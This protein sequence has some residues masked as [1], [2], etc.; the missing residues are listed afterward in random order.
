M[1]DLPFGVDYDLGFAGVALRLARARRAC[2]RLRGVFLVW[3]C[4]YAP[5]VPWLRA[6]CAVGLLVKSLEGSESTRGVFQGTWKPIL[7]LR[8]DSGDEGAAMR[9]DVQA[10]ERAN[11]VLCERSFGMANNVVTGLSDDR[12]T[13]YHA[14]RQHSFMVALYFVHPLSGYGVAMQRKQVVALPQNFVLAGTETLLAATM[15]Q[16]SCLKRAIWNYHSKCYQRLVQLKKI[17]P[18][19]LRWAMVFLLFH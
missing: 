7:L 14:L 11:T 5:M 18:G 13:I 12:T 2:E 3:V 15:C 6:V 17:H 4:S 8:K 1:E 9:R 19:C 16:R 10:I